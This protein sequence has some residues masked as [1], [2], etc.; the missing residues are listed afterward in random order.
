MILLKPVKEYPEGLIAVRS[1]EVAYKVT[2]LVNLKLNKHLRRFPQLQ[3]SETYKGK[4]QE[5]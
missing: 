4:K 3:N 5:V 2:K 1:T